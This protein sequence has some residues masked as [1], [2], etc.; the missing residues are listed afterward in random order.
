MELTNEFRAEL[1]L[2]Q[3]WPLFTDLERLA[4]CVPGAELTEVDDG[5]YRG[6][7]KVTVGRTTARYQGK[8]RVLEL[9]A[10]HH[11]VVVRAEGK[12]SQGHGGA[13]VTL[14][15]TLVA[16]GDATTVRLVSEVS[17]TGR[18]SRAGVDAMSEAASSVVEQFATSAASSLILT[19]PAPTAPA[20]ATPASAAASSS[21]TPAPSA[22][23][24]PRP[25]PTAPQVPSQRSGPSSAAL[26]VGV[27]VI[28][29]GLLRRRRTS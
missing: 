20:A 4:P 17:V 22:R 25:R 5:E 29:L 7:L 16:V 2:D 14:T 3:A 1:P 6:S 23:T 21:A 19:P 9:D 28:L 15:A 13:V 11:R 8:A 26:G 27:L 24:D 10:D 12:E 18:F